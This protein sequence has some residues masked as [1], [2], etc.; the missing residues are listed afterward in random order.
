MI[1]ESRVGSDRALTYRKVFKT[2]AETPRGIVRE[3]R[4]ATGDVDASRISPAWRPGWHQLG[5]PYARRAL[6]VEG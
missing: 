6:G 4:I 1:R 5:N 3:A 2:G